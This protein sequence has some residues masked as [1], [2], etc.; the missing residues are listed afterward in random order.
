VAATGPSGAV[1]TLDGTGSSDPDGDPLTHFWSDTV[2]FDDPTSPT[3]T[4]TF[5]VGTTTVILVVNDGAVDSAP[6]T[7]DITVLDS[8]T[9]PDDV[10]I[11]NYQVDPSSDQFVEVANAG[12][13]PFSLGGCSLVT[14]NVFTEKSISAATVGFSGVLYPGQTMMTHFSGTLPAGPA[15][16]GIYNGPPPPNGTPFSTTN[17]ITGGVYLNNDTVF[18][19][20]HLMVP[21][22]D[23]IYQC[24]YGG[25][26]Q[27]LFTR[28]FQPLANCYP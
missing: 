1:V 2:I 15:A 5:P 6:D 4:A 26:G 25:S 28:P 20:S 23:T 27:G 8:S 17:E 3:P 14:F 21:A 10:L 24:I 11:S 12:T 9:C 19:I 18:G 16:I 13:A 7:V 22:H